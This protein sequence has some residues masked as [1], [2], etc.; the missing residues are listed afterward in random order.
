MRRCIFFGASAAAVHFQYVFFSVVCTSAVWLFAWPAPEARRLP[1]NAIHRHRLMLVS[2][3]VADRLGSF[4]RY[5]NE[6]SAPIV[7]PSTHHS[8]TAQR[9]ITPPAVIELSLAAFTQA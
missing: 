2:M 7:V 5:R 1:G 8:M 4:R 3:H 6:A 9:R